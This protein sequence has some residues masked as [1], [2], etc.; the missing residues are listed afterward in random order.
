MA[1]LK[2]ISV[3]EVKLVIILANKVILMYANNNPFLFLRFYLFIHEIHREREKERG[4]QREK[5]APCR[6]PNLGL[7]PRSPGSGPGLKVALNR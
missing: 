1:R 4:G 3:I 7:D 2:S 6:E 5:Q